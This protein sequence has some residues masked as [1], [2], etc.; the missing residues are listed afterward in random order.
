MIS[1]LIVLCVFLLAVC[2]LAGNATAGSIA[3]VEGSLALTSTSSVPATLGDTTSPVVSVILSQ[4]GTV[5]GHVYTNWSF[6]VNDGTGSL[7]IFGALPSYTPTVGD[8]VEVVGKYAPY[9]EIPEISGVT[10]IAAA[11][12]GNPYPGPMVT[13][14]PAINTSSL[15]LSLAG[16]YLELDNVTISGVGALA[17]STSSNQSATITDSLG[18]SMQLYYWPTSYSAANQNLGGTTVPTG[19]VDIRGIAS[20]YTGATPFVPEFVPISITAVPEPGTLA[21]LGAA[22]ALA[23]AMLFR[24]KLG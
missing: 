17:W 24:R 11:S 19:P 23:A 15:P 2:A 7:D 20:V 1:R 12:S 4:P 21:L 3:D 10:Q 6:L 5:N 14:I 16:Q 9:H 22:T 18:N 8:A 13:T